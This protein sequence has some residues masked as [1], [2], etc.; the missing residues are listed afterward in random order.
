MDA[1]IDPKWRSIDWQRVVQM[2]D[3]SLI[4]LII[5]IVLKIET[6]DSRD[7]RNCFFLI[8]NHLSVYSRMKTIVQTSKSK[9]NDFIVLV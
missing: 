6:A 5:L 7:Y 4:V 2:A 3:L 1:A 9:V 8:I